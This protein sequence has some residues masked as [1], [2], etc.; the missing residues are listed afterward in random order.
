MVAASPHPHPPVTAIVV[1]RN[2]AD[3][4][5]D[6]LRSLAWCDQLIVVDMASADDTAAVALEHTDEVLPLPWSRV[7]EP[8][9]IEAA[10]HARHHWLL[11]LDPDERFPEALI[12]PVREAMHEHTTMGA[13]RLPWKFHFRG[14]P[15]AG[16]IWGGDNRSK[17]FLIHRQRC[18]LA[19]EVHRGFQ[20]RDGFEE[21]RIPPREGWQVEH[22]WMDGYGHFIRK[23][24]RYAIE[25][26][27]S[28]YSAGERVNWRSIAQPFTEM[29]RSLIDFDGIRTGLDGI[30]LSL[31]LGVYQLAGLVSLGVYQWRQQGREHQPEPKADPCEADKRQEARRAA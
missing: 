1:C 29:R 4:L 11:F 25:E 20:L 2:E 17:I 13:L 24:A 28:K 22:L 16:T 18:D 30:A 14:K 26:G 5:R 21:I 7:V 3:K 12:A 23:H 15:L 9:R 8:V 6:C 19:P 31:L 10:K 27:R